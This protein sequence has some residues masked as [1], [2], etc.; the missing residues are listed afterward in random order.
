LGENR[1]ES[2]DEVRRTAQEMYARD[3]AS[4]HLGIELVE[5]RA[6]YARMRMTVVSWMVQ[7]L[8]VCHGGLLFTLADTAMAFASNSRGEVHLSTGGSVE[9]LRPA[10]EG[11]VLTAEATELQRTRRTAVYDVSV[12]T[13]D[14]KAVCHF[15]GRTLGAGPARGTESG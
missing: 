8:G 14:G 12:R 5:A 10:R 6:G 1:N 4:Q 3:C 9:F 13:E 11:Q 2:D 7:G 15:R